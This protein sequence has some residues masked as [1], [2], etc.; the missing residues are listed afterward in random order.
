MGEATGQH[1]GVEPLEVSPVVPYQLG[2]ASQTAQRPHHVVLD[3]RGPL[4]ARIE[5]VIPLEDGVRLELALDGGRLYAAAPLPGPAKGESVALRIDGGVVFEGG[6]QGL[7]VVDAEVAQV[8][9]P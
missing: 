9:S 8:R 5:R 1:Q 6:D 3:P 7:G 2:L 4:S